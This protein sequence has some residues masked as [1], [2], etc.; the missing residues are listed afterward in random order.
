MTRAGYL[1]NIK[2]KRENNK[3]FVA[4]AAIESLFAAL[5]LQLLLDNK[6]VGISHL[7]WRKVLLDCYGG[8]EI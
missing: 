1:G 4:V 8:R 5:T 6:A 3:L 7:I 2:E